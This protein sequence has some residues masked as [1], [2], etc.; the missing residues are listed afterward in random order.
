MQ[1]ECRSMMDET[2]G[3]AEGLGTAPATGHRVAGARLE[4]EGG[5][6]AHPRLVSLCVSMATSGR[7][8][9]AGRSEV[10]AGSGSSA[11]TPGRRLSPA[12]EAS[13]RRGIGLWF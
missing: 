9:W 8:R 11:E 13:F 3:I 5:R 4:S 12:A 7:P 1:A 6:A 10:Q 2:H